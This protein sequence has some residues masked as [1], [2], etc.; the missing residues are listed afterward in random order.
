MFRGGGA[1]R[2]RNVLDGA[3]ED[4]GV[5]DEERK[6]RRRREEA[7]GPVKF[8]EGSVDCVAMIDDS[9]LLSGG[10]S[11]CVHS[12]PSHLVAFAHDLSLAAQLDLSVDHHQE[13]AHLHQAA[14]ARHQRARVRDRGRH[15]HGAVDHGARDAALWRRLR[16]GVVGR[17][18]P[19]VAHRRAHAVLLR[20]RNDRRARVRQL[21]AVD[22][23]R[24]GPRA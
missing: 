9:T 20:D 8:V 19:P 10:D 6:K 3:M 13:E 5:E 14:R 21:A 17:S 12:K 16:V 4:E 23:R 11:G 1:S 2:M 22:A 24:C 18:D 7:K 15:R